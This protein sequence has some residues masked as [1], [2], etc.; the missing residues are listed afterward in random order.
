M[1]SNKFFK[2]NFKMVI[3]TAILLVLGAVIAA[4]MLA[5]NIAT[6][7]N[8]VSAA[9]GEVVPAS[10]L[11]GFVP[12]ALGSGEYFETFVD[13]NVEPNV[14]YYLISD[15]DDLRTLAYFVNTTFTE[16]QATEL[17]LQK[18]YSR[19]SYRMTNHIDLS[20]WTK[21]EPIGTALNPFYGSFDGQGHS[22]YG[23]TIIDDIESPT[24]DTY[25]GLFGN[26]SYLKDA[27]VEY[28]PVIQRLG[29]KDT[30]IKTNREY[31]GAIAAVAYGVN[32]MVYGADAIINPT[33][34]TMQVKEEIGDSEEV[35]RAYSNAQ[36]ALV[37]QD[38]YNVGY[39]EGGNYVGGLAGALYY[40]AVIY[41]CYNAPSTTNAYNADYDVYSSNPNANIGGI[42]G[43]ADFTTMAIIYNCISTVSVS[44]QDATSSSSNIGYI[45]GSK[46]NLAGS[47]Q[48]NY[49]VFYSRD[50]TYVGDYGTG[51]NLAFLTATPD[52]F[53][54]PRKFSITGYN[55]DMWAS[56][57][58]TIWAQQQNINNGIPVLYNVPQLVKFDFVAQDVDGNEL[59][60]SEA[61]SEAVKAADLVAYDGA[62][63]FEQGTDFIVK[64]TA[65]MDY[66]YEFSEWK[67][68]YT[69]N[70]I[71]P[72][73]Y[74]DYI[75][76][77]NISS[78]KL[79]VYH[80][81]SVIAVFD[82]K[83]YKL[84][85]NADPS[86]KID[87]NKTTIAIKDGTSYSYQAAQNGVEVKYDEEVTITG[88]AA[89]GYEITKWTTMYPEAIT[90]TGA[91]ITLSI[92]AYVDA[93]MGDAENN[94]SSAIPE[95]LN[96]LAAIQSKVYEFSM[97]EIEP[98]IGSIQATT[99][100][101]TLEATDS[102][103][104][105]TQ[106]ALNATVADPNY[107]FIS[108]VI[109]FGDGSSIKS[110]LRD[111]SFTVQDQG[112]ITITANFDKKKFYVNIAA[113]AGGSAA[114]TSATISPTT[115]N[116]FYYDET[117]EIL[118]TA[119]T[120]YKLTGLNVYKGSDLVDF[121]SISS[122]EMTFD[123]E[124]GILVIKSLSQDL[125]IVPVFTVQSFNL[126]VE[127]TPSEGATVTHNGESIV[128]TNSF[129]YNTDV[130]LN[131]FVA[132]GY[133]LVSIT[134]DDGSVYE[135]G[136][137][138]KV[139]KDTKVTITL[140][141]KKFVVN[142]TIKYESN[143]TY[144][145]D[146]SCIEGVGQYTYGDEVEISF[147][148]PAM[149]KFSRWDLA[150]N[151]ENSSY[152]STNGTFTCTG[153]EE[154]I[155]LTAYFALVNTK[156]TFTAEGVDEEGGW[157]LYDGDNMVDSQGE[158]AT[159]SYANDVR[160]QLASGYRNN[161]EFTHKYRFSHWEINGMPVS[162]ASDYTF[163]VT[164]EEMTVNAVFV[165]VELSVSANVVRINEATGIYDN[166]SDAGDIKGL[167]ANT[168]Y[169]GDK[170]ALS[171]ST[172]KGYMFLGWYV[173]NANMSGSANGKFITDELTLSLTITSDTKVYAAFERVSNITVQM[174]DKNAGNVTGGGTY[175]VGE[176]VILSAKPNSG[177]RF[178]S[179]Q[180]NG[181]VVS[182]ETNYRLNI[183]RNDR[184]FMAV[185]EPIFKLTLISNNE[186][187][188]KIIGST[189]GNYQDNVTLRAVSENNCSFVGWVINDKIVSTS[190]V[191]NLNLNG[192]IEVRALFKKN[193]DWNILIILVGCVI[194]AG[195]L[196]AGS[197][198][199]IKMRE[200]EP[201]LVRV[202]LNSKDDKEALQK[203]SK[204]E[205]YR[206][207]IEP[208]PT[209][210]TTKA[211]VAP[212]PV[213]KITVAPIN[214]KGE[215]VG[216]TKRAATEKPTLK[217]EET[218]IKPTEKEE[219][220]E[221]IEKPKTTT[222]TK[223]N[224]AQNSKPKASTSKK[225]GA[226]HKGKKSKKKK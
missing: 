177:Y 210:K 190:E 33:F 216:R 39:I 53:L 73:E 56:D 74:E 44:K 82:F 211:N 133:E 130:A 103:E 157:Y 145:I 23:L 76:N 63:L 75:E 217:T 181:S 86:D 189:N 137:F 77:S 107:Q 50:I 135:N 225:S 214:H 93:Y 72:A 165:P 102:V 65:V 176:S 162:S 92:Q 206:D 87:V 122:D 169:Y 24:T 1:N 46:S 41:N 126:T 40:G 67:E 188:G 91:N 127:V 226:N 224:S 115:E 109:Q 100:N 78:T 117:I 153:I 123:L 134:A 95:G 3:Q 203:P 222:A 112:N 11:D 54:V 207:T 79:F 219:K 96:L 60:A 58:D 164:G 35:T 20:K 4:V 179:W 81:A 64:S 99:V 161:G 6:N 94:S 89:T 204:R 101:G 26:V 120:G 191:L 28:R 223:S 166:L 151:Y 140:Q 200:A 141:K 31:V 215:L 8:Y 18:K 168:Y 43:A 209:R 183:T 30:I 66:K 13:S 196:I 194:F 187:Y 70:S 111:Y 185:F 21:W 171:V 178:V 180:E 15:A 159:K 90:G 110:E 105:G 69:A 52:A 116:K 85:L 129:V 121:D 193:F 213:R 148:I 84:S 19:A 5:P 55:P 49:N 104:Y 97:N 14:T 152:D 16:E 59:V 25:A 98:S 9:E 125:R 173:W 155:Y 47:T 172:N 113:V 37:I 186:D 83:T 182:T 29:L 57:T 10:S 7:R 119:S 51:L 34:K 221:K 163:K 27:D 17:E 160:V 175:I 32:P 22:V 212:I 80:D 118:A 88:V 205:Q 192:N 139:L 114:I 62:I 68:Y 124:S 143:S 106:I 146:S 170:V 147:D 198:A 45:I 136:N 156:I 158:I 167:L 199:Y 201:M 132:E 144:S 71:E 195:I 218:P 12:T 128:G 174:S 48:Y 202:L 108:W 150:R 38:C 184:T 2:L 36:A 154:N 142:V 149:F 208:V 197:A 220:S 61:T 42:A 138:V 131:V